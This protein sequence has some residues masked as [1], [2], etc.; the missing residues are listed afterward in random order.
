[1]VQSLFSFATGG[2]FELGSATASR[3]PRLTIIA[4]IGEELSAVLMLYTILIIRGCARRSRC[5][6]ASASCGPGLDA[7]HARLHRG[8]RGDEADPPD[9]HPADADGGS[10]LLAN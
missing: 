10:S 6:T 3:M 9:R 4:A 2:I 7:G 1:M 8:R 5:A